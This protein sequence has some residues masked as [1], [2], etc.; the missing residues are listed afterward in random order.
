MR[1]YNNPAALK[2]GG[3]TV[4]IDGGRGGAAEDESLSEYFWGYI[5]S[6][7]PPL[8]VR[9]KD[10]GSYNRVAWEHHSSWRRDEVTGWK[11]VCVESGSGEIATLPEDELLY[12]DN[13]G[14]TQYGVKALYGSEESGI[15]Y[16]ESPQ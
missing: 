7:I 8:A 10:K 2:V 9:V 13:S 4:S 12:H 11:V 15:A 6:Y 1:S 5:D 14:C 3:G 16:L